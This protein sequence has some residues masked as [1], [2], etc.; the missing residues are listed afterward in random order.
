MSSIFYRNTP[1][2]I[3]AP[4]YYLAQADLIEKY[5]DRLGPR[6]DK[7]QASAREQ[8]ERFRAEAIELQRAVILHTNQRIRARDARGAKNQC[9]A[10]AVGWIRTLRRGAEA[11]SLLVEELRARELRRM[12]RLGQRL[13]TTSAGFVLQEARYLVALLP[14]LK[15]QIS[16]PLAEEE[17]SRGVALTE[18]LEMAVFGVLGTGIEQ[19]A[20]SFK[21]RD[22]WEG[23]EKR[24]IYFL[25]LARLTFSDDPA[26]PDFP[27]RLEFEALDERLMPKREKPAPTTPAAPAKVA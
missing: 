27:L 1:T 14:E 2:L 10:E 6:L 9:V 21:K 15:A 23:L 3:V 18:A 13:V 17:L 22:L 7:E 11:K 4:L 25:R 26:S 20:T 5:L 24:S 19:A 12:V 16:P 8:L